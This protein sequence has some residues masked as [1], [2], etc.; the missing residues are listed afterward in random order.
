MPIAKATGR[1]ANA[2]IRTPTDA[3]NDDADIDEAGT[4]EPSYHLRRALAT[5]CTGQR[6]A[7]RSGAGLA[8]SV[9]GSP[10]GVGLNALKSIGY[11]C[12]SKA[13]GMLG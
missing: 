9:G 6:K 1:Q 5:K 10:T 2:R 13:Q 11:A 7:G 8:N 4:D 12:I 3:R